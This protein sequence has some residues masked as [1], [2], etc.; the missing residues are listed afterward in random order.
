M[1]ERPLLRVEHLGVR[2]AASHAAALEDV[3]LHLMTG[4][5][6]AVIGESG[7]GK[8]TFAR[9]IAHLLPPGA[10]RSGEI[11]WPALDAQPAPGR[12]LAYVLQ[13]P[14]ASLDPVMTIGEQV[15]EGAVAH[16]GLSWG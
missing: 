12:D 2:Y 8:S 7:S 16:L 15:A 9:T 4:E 13:D 6:L 11:E 1:V 14:S 5:R 3:S 10:E